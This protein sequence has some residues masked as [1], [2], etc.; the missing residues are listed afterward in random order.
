M[1]PA[2]DGVSLIVYDRADAGPYQP[3]VC[4]IFHRQALLQPDVAL[5]KSRF[6]KLS[7]SVSGQSTLETNSGRLLSI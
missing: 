2:E 5:F 6:I 4:H 7:Q 1:D 3:A